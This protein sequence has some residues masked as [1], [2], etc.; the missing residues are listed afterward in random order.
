MDLMSS[1]SV[2][3]RLRVRHSRG[4]PFEATC[5][6]ALLLL[7]MVGC[8]MRPTV[9]ATRSSTQSSEDVIIRSFGQVV[10]VQVRQ[11]LR[12]ARPADFSDWQVD[13]S[14]DVLKA[15]TPPDQMRSPGP[16]GWRFQAIARGETDLVVT[17]VATSD[18][19]SAAPARFAVTIRVQ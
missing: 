8:D 14:S 7:L 4:K 9:A 12:V 6:S 19:T 10:T 2:R 1:S 11:T 3:L 13:Y 15:L 18:V 16:D 17:P 5:C